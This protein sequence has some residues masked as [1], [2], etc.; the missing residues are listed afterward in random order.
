MQFKTRTLR[1]PWHIT[2]IAW[3]GFAATMVLLARGQA[4]A[5]GVSSVVAMTS[6]MTATVTAPASRGRHLAWMVFGLIA[7]LA[8][9]N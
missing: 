9:L 6:G 2:S 5:Q 4:M 7:S 1:M 8:A 3:C